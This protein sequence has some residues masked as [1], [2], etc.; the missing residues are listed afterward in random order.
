MKLDE[1]IKLDF[2]FA[3]MLKK[4]V[5]LKMLRNVLLFIGLIF[6]T[7]WFIFKDQDMNELYN[8]LI[9]VDLKY[10]ILGVI[11][12]FGYYFMESYNVKSLLKALGDKNISIFSALKFT[13][14][15]FFFSAI[16]PAATGG[17]PVEVYYM[18]KE[19][20]SGANATMALLIQLCGFQISTLSIGLVCAILN[21]SILK[22]GLIWFF[23][24]GF[25]INGAA[26]SLMLI[27]VFSQKL[28]KK[29]SNLIMKLLKKFKVKDLDIKREKLQSAINQYNE[30]SE[31]I[32]SHKI[33]FIKAIIRVFI[34]IVLY[35][36]VPICVYKA[37]GLSS[38]SIIELFSMQAILYTTVS[39]L[40]LPGAIGV[41]ETIFLKIFGVAFS[42]KLLSGAM[43]L[44]RGISFYLYVIISLIIVIINSMVKKKVIGE[45]DNRVLEIDKEITKARMN[46]TKLA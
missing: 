6:L 18:T 36:M 2:S 4:K 39:G 28:T 37:F 25:T 21:P 16:T 1:I 5:N 35:Y 11:I 3:K 29:L 31:F 7:F 45:I 13:F 34:Q 32:K 41:S 10:V 15:G 38:H 12:M 27:C 14:I 30:S 43:L 17:Q 46:N 19:K 23:I 26:L 8:V 20:I 9:S 24:L 22:D 44:S 40:P 42:D 33:E